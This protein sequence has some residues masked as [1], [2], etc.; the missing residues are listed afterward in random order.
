MFTTIFALVLVFLFAIQKFSHQIQIVAGD[1][2]KDILNRFTNKPIKGIVSGA[3]IS[4]L[5]QSSTATSIILVGLVNGGLIPVY[6]AISV[7]IGA[8]IGTTITAQLVAFNM[9]Y[10]APIIVIA[11]FIV[12]HTHSSLR[13]YGKAIFYFGVIFLALF[14]ISS[15]VTPF[16]DHPGVIAFFESLDNPFSA[17]AIGAII[18]VVLQSSSALTGLI[19]ILATQGL[20]GLPAA[21]GFLFGASIG[22]PVTAI[23][24]STSANLG[25]KKV[26]MAHAF[27]NLLGVIIF[28]P[29]SALFIYF[30]QATS[31]NLV[32]QIVNAHFI[33]NV[34]CA[35]LCFVF[36]K[37]FDYIVEKSTVAMYKK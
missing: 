9:T 20:V 36:F 35:I 7:I 2:L 37:Q 12:S 28:M 19:L 32:Q 16:R 8:N 31:N 17:I 25:A 6:N 26:A 24:A 18:T 33:F 34:S 21:V 4:S 3:L 23:I 22:S 1:K 15:L 29:I 27:F 5:L 10:L 13:R 11:G 14:L 30:I